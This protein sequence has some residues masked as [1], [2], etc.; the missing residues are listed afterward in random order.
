MSLTVF[1]A[2]LGQPP[3]QASD[4]AHPELGGAFAAARSA[5]AAVFNSY[6]AVDLDQALPT[7]TATVKTAWGDSAPG[8]L[9]PNAGTDVVLIRSGAVLRFT[10]TKT[11][12]SVPFERYSVVG[13]VIG[14]LNPTTSITWR[15][16]AMTGIN[17]PSLSW[18]LF[19]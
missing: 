13:H 14:V 7:I 11:P 8:E 1:G 3:A 4:P 15:V 19:H 2:V 5:T 16:V 12:P 9:I 6:S 10:V 18:K 17:G